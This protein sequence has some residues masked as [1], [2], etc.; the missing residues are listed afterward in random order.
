MPVRLGWFLW[1]C[2]VGALVRDESSSSMGLWSGGGGPRLSCS[3]KDLCCPSSRWCWASL[4]VGFLNLVNVGIRCWVNH[5]GSSPR[6][7]VPQRMM[8]RNSKFVQKWYLIFKSYACHA[9]I[10]EWKHIFSIFYAQIKV[11]KDTCVHYLLI[12]LRNP[13]TSSF[14]EQRE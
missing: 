2:E 13:R 6:N 9:I 1:S 12:F 5:P 11:V 14:M 10:I 7:S 4:V 3:C 8:L